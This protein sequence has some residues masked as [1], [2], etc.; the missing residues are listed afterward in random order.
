MLVKKI[1][2]LITKKTTMLRQPI[3]PEIKIAVTLR[4][5]ATGI[6]WSYKSNVPISIPQ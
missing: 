5:L 6:V 2:A 1:A 3:D 4:F